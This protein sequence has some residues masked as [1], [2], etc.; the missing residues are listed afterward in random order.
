VVLLVLTSGEAASIGRERGIAPTELAVL[1]EKRLHR[2]T[3]WLQLDQ[4]LLARLPDGELASLPLG[5]LSASIRSVLE[6]FKP[7]VVL[8]HDARGVN[9]HPDHIA[10]HWAMRCALQDSSVLRFAQVVH[11]EVQAPRAAPRLLFSTPSERIHCEIRLSPAE[12]EVKERCLLEHEA[13]VTTD[14]LRAEQENLLWR[15]PLE[16]WQFFG[17]RFQTRTSLLEELPIDSP[18]Y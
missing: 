17:E 6:E 13:I 12:T 9:A 3:E 10:T 16:Q 5:V 15:E 7:Q 11:G 1:R 18:L 2:V 8:G 14:R 4:L